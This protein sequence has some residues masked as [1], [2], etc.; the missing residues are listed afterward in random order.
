MRDVKR[1]YLC[2]ALVAATVAGCQ[3]R[4][5][6]RPGEGRKEVI[7]GHTYAQVWD[8]SDKVART[9]FGVKEHDRATG[10]IIAER[11]VSV[12]SYGAWIGIYVTP[13]QGTGRSFT[14]EVVSRSRVT[15]DIGVY[16][17]ETKVLGDVKDTLAGRP[18]EKV[19]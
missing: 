3:T 14:V 5:D 8:A 18:I 6:V 9:H 7:E 13:P 12:W 10:T 19:P 17:W 15:S 4:S 1:G 2:L 11:P 16:D